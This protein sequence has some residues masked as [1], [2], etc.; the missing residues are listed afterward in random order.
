MSAVKNSL[1]VGSVLL[2]GFVVAVGLGCWLLLKMSRRG[3]AFLEERAGNAAVRKREQL[4]SEV[5]RPAHTDSPGDSAGLRGEPF[6]YK[7]GW[8]AIRSEDATRVIDVLGLRAPT[9]LGWT[10]GVGAAYGRGMFVTPTI[11][12]WTLVMGAELFD[13]STS[14]SKVS[15]Q[16]GCEVQV[17]ATYRVSDSHLWERA[18]GSG[19]HRFF[20]IEQGEVTVEG[21]PTDIERDLGIDEFVAAW[22][23]DDFDGVDIDDPNE[24]TVMTVAGNWSLDPSQLSNP[25][26]RLGWYSAT[27]SNRKFKR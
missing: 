3:N 12:G 22:T 20:S 18:S 15:A 27:W 14:A 17:F 6:G 11:N 16:L 8:M 5:T 26:D 24:V 23:S 19:Q 1:G 2:L 4:R 13:G 7:T 10:A 25:D 21:P 9:R